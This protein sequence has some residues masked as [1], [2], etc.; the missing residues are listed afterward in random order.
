MTPASLFDLFAPRRWSRA[1]AAFA[2]GFSVSQSQMEAMGSALASIRDRGVLACGVDTGL[3]G[4][5]EQ[6]SDGTWRGFEIDLCHAY[7]A[8]F[9]GDATRVRF[10]PLTTAERLPALEEGRVDIL[11]RN[12]SWT[13]SR[14]ARMKVNFAG[15]YYYDGQGFL[16]PAD[17]GVASAREL[18]GARACVQD[19]TT[20]VLNLTDYADI[21]GLTLTPVL[22]DTPAEARAAYEAGR[23]D[24][25]TSDISALAAL[26]RGLAAPDDHVILPDVISK[27]PLSVVVAARDPRF[28]EAARWVLHAL[29]TAEE[30]GVTAANARALRAEARS[31]VVRRLLGA[32]GAMGEGLGLNADFA[33]NAITARGHYGEMFARHLGETSPLRLER[34][35]NAQWSDGGLIYAPPFR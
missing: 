12:T 16:A 8:A 1:A 29:V 34:G 25:L 33:L 13:L 6:D 3:P 10:V 26:R 4:F 23:C 9:L 7:A 22:S 18:S 28:A 2:V 5:A 27:E 32:E 14:A 11:L 17:L 19:A 20:S 35:L 31:P 30:Y 24:V 21:Y 15:I